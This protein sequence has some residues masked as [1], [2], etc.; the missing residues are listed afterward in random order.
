MT[1]YGTVQYSSTVADLFDSDDILYY[2]I[3]KAGCYAFNSSSFPK[4]FHGSGSVDPCP[5][6]T[7][8]DPTNTHFRAMVKNFFKIELR[9]LL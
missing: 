2:T 6:S 4:I 3:L 1:D 5:D 7:D 9:K 8:L